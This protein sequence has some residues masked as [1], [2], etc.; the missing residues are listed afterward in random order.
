MHLHS[1]HTGGAM[2]R[3]RLGPAGGVAQDPGS[4]ASPPEKAVSPGSRTTTRTGHAGA[5]ILNTELT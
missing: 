3:P 5:W 4:T 1:A 2:R